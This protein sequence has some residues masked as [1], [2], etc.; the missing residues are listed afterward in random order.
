[1]KSRNEKKRNAPTNVEDLETA[2]AINK[3][4]KGKQVESDEG[5]DF[6]ESA[7]DVSSYG[8]E[9][10]VDSELSQEKKPTKKGKATNVKNATGPKEPK[11][12]KAPKAE[13]GPS[14]KELKEQDKA[15][16]LAL[17]DQRD[18]IPLFTNHSKQETD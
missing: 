9:S 17:R 8:E 6:D 13:K 4:K 15:A 11:A 3:P 18:K 2:I 10:V 5:S 1:M 16:E 14:K 7:D 12:A